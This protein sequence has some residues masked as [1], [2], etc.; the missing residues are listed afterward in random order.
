MENYDLVLIGSTFLAVG[1]AK[2][3]KGKCL[4]IEPKGKPGYEFVDS[5]NM[6]SAY[7]KKCVTKACKEFKEHLKNHELFADLF[8][9]EWTA[10]FSEYICKNNIDI[11][12]FTNVLKIE[13]F[14]NG[15]KLTIYNSLGKG[16][17]T[18]ERVIDT[19]TNSFT[20][21]TLNAVVYGDEFYPFAGGMTETYHRDNVRIVEF[22]IPN[23]YD[24]PQ[25]R[26]LVYSLWASRPEK[27]KDTRIA[28]V[29]DIFFEKSDIE[30][31]TIDFCHSEMYSTYYENPILAFDK[32]VSIG[33]ALSV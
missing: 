25:A 20:Y 9:P 6:G 27:L 31:T 28:A 29:A 8:V 13:N 11:L 17:I 12:L 2:G 7:N 21:K 23:G 22:R 14:E 3:F 1:I 4:I 5:F 32:G 10:F 19:R 26:D 24:Y 16:E 33:G 18:A 15:K 30:N